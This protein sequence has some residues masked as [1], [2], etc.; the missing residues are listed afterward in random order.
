MKA[1]HSIYGEKKSLA[2]L[3]KLTGETLKLA[4]LIRQVIALT[5]EFRKWQ[6]EH[7]IAVHKPEK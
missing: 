3:Y 7:H 4:E 2:F 6:Q 1:I 5:K